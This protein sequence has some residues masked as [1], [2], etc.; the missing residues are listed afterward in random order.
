MY[1]TFR[2]NVWKGNN[3]I[4]NEREISINILNNIFINSKIDKNSK[5][6]QTSEDAEEI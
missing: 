1:D 6:V 4:N 5:N 3:Y 2:K